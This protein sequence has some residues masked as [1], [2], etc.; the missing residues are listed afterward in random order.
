[1]LTKPKGPVPITHYTI[2]PTTACNA[3]CYYCF[4]KGT[5]VETMTEQTANDVVEFIKKHHGGEKVSI[6]WFGGEPSLC[7]NRITQ[8][9]NGLRVNGV[10]FVSQMISNGYAFDEGLVEEAVNNWNLRF[11][12]IT[13]DGIG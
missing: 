4:E 1:M 9:S 3:R 8:I 2:L 11:I 10:K 12:Q 6:L 7:P 5:K 13:F